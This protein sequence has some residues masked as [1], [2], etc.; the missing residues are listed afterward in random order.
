MS[1]CPMPPPSTLHREMT[2]WL[3]LM[4]VRAV[5]SSRHVDRPDLPVQRSEPSSGSR[6]TVGEIEDADPAEQAA[7]VDALHRVRDGEP[8]ARLEERPRDVRRPDAPARRRDRWRSTVDPPMRPRPRS[9]RRPS[10]RA[11]RMPGTAMLAEIVAERRIDHV[12][13]VIE[14]SGEQAIPPVERERR[15]IR[16]P[17]E[18]DRR[19]AEDLAHPPVGRSTSPSPRH[20]AHPR[21]A[22]HRT[23]RVHGERSGPRLDPDRTGDASSAFEIEDDEIRLR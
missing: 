20:R 10:P 14:A 11:P 22:M 17:V 21:S 18:R 8:G 6:R 12:D 3:A 16:V 7:A 2:G 5:P 13:A 19:L 15:C 23:V 4:V 9:S 1:R